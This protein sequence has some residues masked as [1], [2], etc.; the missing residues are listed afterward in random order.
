MYKQTQNSDVLSPSDIGQ[1][2]LVVRTTVSR[3]RMIWSAE[4]D[5]LLGTVSDAAIA[6]R[7]NIA[8]IS[9]SKRRTK[10]GI[11]FFGRTVL[12]QNPKMDALLGRISDPDIAQKF[13]CKA[14]QVRARRKE[15]GIPSIRRWSESLK[16][17]VARGEV[18]PEPPEPPVVA[19]GHRILI[20]R[21]E[22][23]SVVE[24]LELTSYLQN[25]LSE[26]LSLSLELPD[27]P[28]CYSDRTSLSQVPISKRR[29]PSPYFEC[30][31]CKKKFTRLTGTPLAGIH[32]LTL[33]SAFISLLS[34]Q[35]SYEEARKRLGVGHKLVADWTKK[36]RLW[37][38]KH[39]PSGKWEAR[40]R[41]G[42]KPRPHI[43]CPRCGVDGEKR[44]SGRDH[45]AGRHLSCP[46]CCSRFSVRDAEY[47]ARQKIQL[48]VWYDPIERAPIGI[49]TAR[50]LSAPFNCI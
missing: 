4:A 41:L 15:L 14:Y 2:V 47:L 18:L 43:R 30:K 12:E 25:A 31:A 38:L 34:R 13:G 49:P 45:I 27:C 23:L 5:A 35:L 11:P 6:A 22:D 24:D 40:V 17:I 10:L 9:V 46:V 21:L 50:Q 33:I 28:R 48:K 19:S 39:D 3:N 7:F 20:D 29:Y 42:I 26:V 16:R 44:F 37:L 1:R 8:V 32:D 36:F